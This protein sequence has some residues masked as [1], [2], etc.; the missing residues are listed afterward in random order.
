M[1]KHSIG[2]VAKTKFAIQKFLI[3]NYKPDDYFDDVEQGNFYLKFE[4]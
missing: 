2:G 3:E 4:V 1:G